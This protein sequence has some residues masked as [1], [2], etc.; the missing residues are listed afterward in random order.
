MCNLRESEIQAK[1]RAV[2]SHRA[3]GTR[4]FRN[5]TGKGKIAARDCAYC[6]KN[7]SWIE[8]GLSVGSSD[9]IGI[10]RHLVTEDDVGEHLGLFFG[11]EI[12][13]P[14]GK[15]SPEQEVWQKTIRQFG[16][17]SEILRS[18][19]DAITLLKRLG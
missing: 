2:L 14:K 6:Q 8:W 19:E 1:C 13:T 15:V 16:G 18:E 12:K 11:A 17:I 9:L 5:N 3:A 7:G 4:V 10:H